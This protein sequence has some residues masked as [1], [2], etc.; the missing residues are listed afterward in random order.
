MIKINFNVYRNSLFTCWYHCLSSLH[1]NT[2]WPLTSPSS[3]SNLIPVDVNWVVNVHPIQPGTESFSTPWHHHHDNIIISSTTLLLPSDFW[4]CCVCQCMTFVN[5]ITDI[6]LRS[7]VSLRVDEL[8]FG[9]K[10]LSSSA[11]GSVSSCC[12]SAFQQA[13]PERIT[14]TSAQK[15]WQPLTQNPHPHLTQHVDVD[16]NEPSYPMESCL[17]AC[18]PLWW[19]Y[20]MQLHRAFSGQTHAL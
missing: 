17:E 18:C 4:L 12:Q 6:I 7:E 5:D 1:L 20:F 11:E 3:Q 16:E 15:L 8:D 2:I 10:S 13:K 19:F 14:N 9:L